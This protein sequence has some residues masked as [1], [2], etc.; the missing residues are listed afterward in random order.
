MIDLFTK[1]EKLFICF[2]LLAIIVGAGFKIYRSYS[3]VYPKLVEHGDIKE[4]E[5]QI[6]QKAALIDS[7]LLEV[8]ALTFNKAN[9]IE[10]EASLLN[11][12]SSTESN[13]EGWLIEINSATTTELARLPQIGPVLANR[14]VEYR[15][16]YGTFKD[17]DEL[18]K[19]K[20]IGEKKLNLIRAY[21]Y[22]KQKK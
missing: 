6:P 3:R 21:L 16:T 2:L 11:I 18:I 4:T 20:G 13:K 5:Q 17:I 12:D 14:I 19:V 8:K 1:Q 9:L 15:N 10:K 22:I 7:S